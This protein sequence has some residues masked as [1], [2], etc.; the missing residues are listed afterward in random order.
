MKDTDAGIRE[1]GEALS[2]PVFVVQ[3][4][5]DGPGHEHGDH[6]SHRFPLPV[7]VVLGYVLELAPRLQ[8]LRGNGTAQSGGVAGVRAPMGGSVIW[9][10][11]RGKEDRGGG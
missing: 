4:R 2:S 1:E 3:V 8:F 5:V 7:E 9:K 10:V 11:G 6:R